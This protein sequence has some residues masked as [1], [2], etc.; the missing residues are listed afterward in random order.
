M[1]RSSGLPCSPIGASVSF[2]N[3]GGGHRA[4][5]ADQRM[6]NDKTIRKYVSSG[7]TTVYKLP[8]EA[9]PNHVTNCYLVLTDPITLL[10][11]ASGW[12]MANREL[13]ACFDRLR[14]DFGEKLSLKDIDRVIITHGHIDHFG[15]VNFVIDESAA[16]LCIHEIG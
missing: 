8:V 5:G 4:S 1:G 15:G 2:S 3:S 11:T 9:F 10:D 14:Q 7:G 13:V 6:R 12:D 16:D